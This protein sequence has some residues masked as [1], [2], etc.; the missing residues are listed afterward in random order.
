M[1][2]RSLSP[3]KLEWALIAANALVRFS[4]AVS[5]GNTS[6]QAS[7]LDFWTVCF[8]A[9]RLS[10]VRDSRATARF[11]YLGELR[12]RAIPVPC[13]P[14]QFVLFCLSLFLRVL[15]RTVSGP[16]PSRIARP[17]GGGIVS[18]SDVL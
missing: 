1:A 9:R 4:G 15:I 3:E 5:V 13:G 2:T 6:I 17:L 11:P 14:R 10:L 12:I 18:L 7:G 8:T 16:A